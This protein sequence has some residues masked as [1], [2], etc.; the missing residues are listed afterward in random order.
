MI[1]RWPI[2]YMCFRSP[3]R[4]RERGYILLTLMLFVALLL[5][6]VALV[7]ALTAMQL[8]I[9]GREVAIDPGV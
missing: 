8:A 3:I 9:H 7:S 6:T 2:A 4:R 1:T 5:I